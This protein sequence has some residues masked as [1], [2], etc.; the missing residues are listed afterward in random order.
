[1]L[2]EITPV[3]LTYNEAPNIG[4]ALSMLAWA[5]DI[6]VVDSLSDDETPAIA[7]SFPTVRFFQRPFDNHAAQWNYALRETGITTEWVLA[8]DA[9]YILSE[10]LIAEL[11]SVEPRPD[12]GGFETRFQYCIYGRPLRGST[13][14][15]VV[16]L[17]R[18]AGARYEQDGHT[19]R[20]RPSGTI[21]K[22]QGLIRHDDRK[23]VAHWCA[24]Q[25]RYMALEADK[26][27]HTPA[28]E[29]PL[30]DRIRRAIVL[31]P[32]LMLFYCAFVKGN[33]L[34]GRAGLYYVCQRTA[35][36][37]LLSLHLLQRRLGGTPGER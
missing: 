6:V 33:I 14:R 37:L 4:R 5:R 13:Y 28:R 24:A 17:F 36:E 22:L 21:E 26:L 32:P 7:K 18:R 11:R 1:M 8:L 34:D 30:Q 27:C 29:L 35:A 15:P 9:D 12:T 19:Q 10:A 31:A 25:N 2:S 3:V 16:T 20:V 23:S